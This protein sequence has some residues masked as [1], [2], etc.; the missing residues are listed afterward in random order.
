MSTRV[1]STTRHWLA[2][3]ALALTV[4]AAP[5]LADPPSRVVR[6]GYIGGDVSLQLAGDEGRWVQANLNRPLIPGDALYTDRASRVEM[7]LGSATVRLDERSHF[8]MLAL[9]DSFAQIE[10]TEGVLDLNVRRVFDG[11]SYEID[12][13]T[14]AF[15]VDRAGR[16]RI[17]IAPDGS[18][19]MISV[20]DGSG[21]VYGENDARYTVRDRQSYRFHDAGL[22]DYEVFDLP[23]E[24]DFDRWAYE[25]EDRYA[26]SE[27]RRYVSE[28]VIGYAD[29]DHYGSW[30]TAATYGS[31]W[32][33]TRVE[34]GWAPYRHGH[35]SWIDPWGWTWVDRSPWG[36]APFHYGRWA[37]VGSRWGWVPGPRHVRPIYAP[38]LVA[39]V[40]GNNWGVSISGGGPVGWFP[41]GP[42][43]VYVP[44][45]R[46]SRDYFN[47]INV[48][49]TTII[50]N[51]YITNVYNDYSRGRSVNNF[52][53][54]YRNNERAF[55]AVPREAFVN[56]RGV[57]R[58]RLDIDRAQFGRGEVLT[59]V[60]VKPVAAS[61]T[62]GAEVRNRLNV[63]SAD[64]SRRE[65]IAR[66]APP[67]RP[68]GVEGRMQAIERNDNQPIAVDQ[69]RRLSTE[70]SR[71]GNARAERIRVV[72]NP[73]ANAAAPQPLPPRSPSERVRRDGATPG[74]QRI[75]PI[76]RAP[77][78]DARNG[79][80]NGARTPVERARRDDVSTPARPAPG[81]QRITPIER[82]PASDARRGRDD[83][84]RTPVERERR[85]PSSG[86]APGRDNVDRGRSDLP[87]RR[88]TPR[89]EATP[90]ARQPQVER[91]A[92]V[93]EMPQQRA[94]P[95]PQ[96]R[97]APQPQ[98]RAAPQ[99]QQR[100][101]EMPQQRA[102][103]QPQQRAAPQ[104]QQRA[105]P[106]PQQRAAPQPQQRAAPQPQQ[107]AAP[108]PQ[109]RAAPQPQ[110]RAAPQPQQRAAPPP[111]Q[112][113]PQQAPPRENR[114][115]DADS[116]DKQERARR[117]ND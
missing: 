58:S 51:T 3:A 47:N 45:Y 78:A 56:A 59:R 73:A 74:D 72:G 88:L 108:Q 8:R 113:A 52:N 99:P 9:D 90:A 117:R 100:Q 43:D 76:E 103:P 22:R 71:E 93:R 75:T 89:N 15:V 83:E 65:V 112:R 70:R 54:A 55:T 62:G 86:Y 63:P 109:Q 6:L 2:A 11:D 46:G 37:Y 67:P 98:Q 82:A 48:R 107:R 28:E 39:F 14:L 16:Y 69:M 34:A 21:T 104:P 23:R 64:V 31:I 68:L 81:D 92:P 38:A 33:P 105:A 111:Q 10:L 79:R 42:R 101:R 20:F 80:D 114:K 57:E 1:R 26:R 61:F 96:Q 85:L 29:L 116:E 66:K 40:G 18:S 4:A 17:D 49:N 115:K 24:D 50:N 5:V 91:S 87:E 77:A 7:Q 13:P 106:Q 84:A 60:N 27:S 102:A 53:Y 41:L 110:Q 36:F 44:W 94:A 35:W 19:T 32:Y 97:A 30:S 25:R 12:T 95:Q